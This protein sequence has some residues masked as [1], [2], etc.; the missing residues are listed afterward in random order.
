WRLVATP[1]APGYGDWNWQLLRPPV[2]RPRARPSKMFRWAR[3]TNGEPG[4]WS[5]DRTAHTD[6]R[7]TLTLGYRYKQFLETWNPTIGVPHHIRLPV[8]Q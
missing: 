7:L 8:Q 4:L 2:Q 5:I 1:H 3:F 6:Q